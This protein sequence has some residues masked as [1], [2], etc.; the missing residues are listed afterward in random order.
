MGYVYKY[1]HKETGK[2]YIGSY[3]GSKKNY[4]GSGKLWCKVKKKYGLDSFILEILYEGDDFR[5]IEQKILIELDARNDVMSYNLI[6]ESCGASL[7]GEQN[8][9]YGRKL[10][11]D[12]RY[13][14][15]SGFRGKKRPDHSEKMTGEGNPMHGRNDQTHGLRKFDL[16]RKGKKCEE[17]YG[18]EKA[19]EIKSKIREANLGSTK[20]GTSKANFGGGNPSAKRII[21][22]SIEY[23]CIKEAME[24]LGLSRYNI[25]QICEFVKSEK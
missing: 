14:C 1:T 7:P 20:P 5:E 18:E 15:G 10:T 16:Y 22:N 17:I 13:V 9:M 4:S 23:S 2:W 11:P 12:E 8:G 25:L 3:N 21:I 6:N 19:K 24:K